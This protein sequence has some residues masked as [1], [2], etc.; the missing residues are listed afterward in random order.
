MTEAELEQKVE[1]LEQEVK[2]LECQIADLEM[3]GGINDLENFKF[4]LKKDGLWCDNLEKFIEHYL[5][6]HND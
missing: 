5:R 1:E 4:E 2:N 6:Y 3:K